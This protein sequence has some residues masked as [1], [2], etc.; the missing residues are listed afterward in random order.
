M[1]VGE[2]C[3]AGWSTKRGDTDGRSSRSIAHSP[4]SKRCSACGH[5]LESLSL[6]V[7]EWTCPTCGAVHARDVNAATNTKAAGRIPCSPE[8]EQVE[9]APLMEGR[10]GAPGRYRKSASRGV[11]SHPLMS[12]YFLIR[13]GFAQAFCECI[14][15]YGP[16]DR[17]SVPLKL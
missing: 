10:G 4:R 3:C 16:S 9:T 1:W 5:E 7:R 14:R 2:N 13:I 6:A 15:R 11:E 17:K 8:D 12:F